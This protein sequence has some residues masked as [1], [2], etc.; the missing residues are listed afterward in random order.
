[1]SVDLPTPMALYLAAESRGD[2]ETLAECFA[3]QAIVRDEGQT[4]ESLAAIK[5]WM[6]ETQKKYEHTIEPLTSARKGSKTIV[7]NR[8]TGNF[9]GNPIDLLFIFGLDGDKIASLEIRS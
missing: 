3:E 5:Q 4:I 2:T 9:P 7:T 1:M 8:L 6:A